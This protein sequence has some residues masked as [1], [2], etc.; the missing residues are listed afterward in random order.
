M[1]KLIQLIAEWRARLNRVRVLA[2][3]DGGH[4][5]IW[6]IRARILAFLI[7]R[8]QDAAHEEASFVT[9]G[10]RST[11][12]PLSFCAVVSADGPPPRSGAHIIALLEDIRVCNRREKRRLGWLWTPRPPA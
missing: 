2:E 3:D 6:R 1:N 10:A 4:A 8:Y 11:P 5:W 7:S 12:P 9:G